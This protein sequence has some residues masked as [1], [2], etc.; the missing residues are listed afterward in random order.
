MNIQLHQEEVNTKSKENIFNKYLEAYQTDMLRI[1]HKHRRSNHILSVEEI[2]SEANLLISKKKE[3]IISI[4]NFNENNFKKIAYAY[5]RNAIKWSAWRENDAKQKQGVVDGFMYD[6]GSGETLTTF[7]FALNQSDYSEEDKTD[8]HDEHDRH[9]NSINFFRSFL[10]KSQCEIMDY[11]LEG[12]DVYEIASIYNISR[13]A[14]DFKVQDIRAKIKNH[15][16]FR[17]GLSSKSLKDATFDCISKGQDAIN[18]FFKETKVEFSD[19]DLHSLKNILLSSPKFYTAEEI[20]KKYFDSKFSEILIY[21]RARSIGLNF[22]MTKKRPTYAFNE[23]QEKLLINLFKKGRDAKFIAKKMCLREK[24]IIHKQYHMFK[25]GIFHE[26]FKQRNDRLKL[27]KI[28]FKSKLFDYRRPKK[29]QL[30]DSDKENILNILKSQGDKYNLKNISR[31][32]KIPLKIISGYRSVLIR[33]KLLPK[34]GN[35]KRISKFSR[36]QYS[37]LIASINQ[38][39]SIKYTIEKTGINKDSLRGMCLNAYKNKLITKDQ[40]VNFYKIT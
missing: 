20:N 9:K 5:V 24:S 16:S 1:I 8:L 25:Q 21:K 27:L 29:Y 11:L 15:P 22:L 32:L 3:H 13:Q 14:V 37:D 19:K 6:E 38:G 31:K 17:D 39:K 4:D 23:A 34:L 18:N 28:V 33:K 40:L 30:T 2:A 35:K 12:K 36:K 10:T 26:T 7:D